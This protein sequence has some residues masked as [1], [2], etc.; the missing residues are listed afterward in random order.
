M[1]DSRVRKAL[2]HAVE[3]TSINDAIYAGGSLIADFMI[4]P[5]ALY[6]AAIDR[7]ITKY[8]YDLRRSEQLMNEA[9]FVRGS[10]G[11][12]GGADGRF[13]IESKANASSDNDTH[14]DLYPHIGKLI[15]ID[16]LGSES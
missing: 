12:Y 16:G 8:P 1:L 4:P 6:G 13:V 15:A 7:A 3:K 11:M 14:A 9:G 5:V 10:D 2:G